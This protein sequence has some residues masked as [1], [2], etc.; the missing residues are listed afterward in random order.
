MRYRFF[1]TAIVIV[2][3]LGCKDFSNKREACNSESE[4]IEKEVYVS[5]VW[6]GDNG[7]GTYTNPILHADYSDPD[8]V[9]VGDDFYMTV[10]SFNASPGLPILHSKDLVNWQII[11]HA[12]K[13]LPAKVYDVPQPSKGVWAPCIRH[14]NGEFYIFWGDPDLGIFMV[15]TDDP[16]GDWSAPVMVAEGTGAGMIDPSPLW[17]D[18][19]NAYLV[20]AWA[21]SRA[22]V[23]S[24]LTVYK[25]SPDGTSILD[26]G[27]NIYSGHDY[28]HTVEGP[29]FMKRNEYFYIF[30]PAGGVE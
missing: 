6:T 18:D 17:D 1:L 2:F 4:K 11:N 20:T 8:V 14:H 23:N 3:C 15:K 26:N 24:I 29:K 5:D 13:Q 10:S 9:R 12:L 16:G 7:D 25:M 21:G 30:A 19:G 22:G 28:N 27:R